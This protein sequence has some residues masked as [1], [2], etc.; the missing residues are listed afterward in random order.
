MQTLPIP[1]PAAEKKPD[2]H[3]S[4]ASGVTNE[5]SSRMRGAGAGGQGKSDASFPLTSPASGQAKGASAP[6]P[7][8]GSGL[9]AAAEAYRRK[10]M[11]DNLVPGGRVFPDRQQGGPPSSSFPSTDSQASGSSTLPNVS[12]AVYDA[13]FTADGNDTVA[14][15]GSSA[16]Y[17]ASSSSSYPSSSSTISGSSAMDFS[18][19]C[20][21][22]GHAMSRRDNAS[23]CV[24]VGGKWAYFNPKLDTLSAFLISG[25]HKMAQSNPGQPLSFSVTSNGMSSADVTTVAGSRKLYY[26]PG[27]AGG[28]GGGSGSGRYFPLYTAI[29]HLDKG[30][31]VS[32]TFDEGCLCGSLSDS[33][34]TNYLEGSLAADPAAQE[35]AGKHMKSCFIPEEQ[36]T[37]MEGAG[38]ANPNAN[39]CDLKL[40]VVWAGEDSK[41]NKMR[42]ANHR[43]SRYN[44]FPVQLN[45]LWGRIRNVFTDLNT[46]VFPDDISQ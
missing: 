28:G 25:S 46:R 27:G 37:A 36:C 3:G 45:S 17:P 33:C 8:S 24:E 39:S 6:L 40:F 16:F 22:P 42:T 9:D 14:G 44:A 10:R 1:A 18:S 35:L 38:V 7:G 4:T 32:V 11:P 41:Q 34:A 31:V 21:V 12:G 19:G 15:N 13:N 29:I 30:K 5:A 43:F 26:Q 2:A 23:V 20:G